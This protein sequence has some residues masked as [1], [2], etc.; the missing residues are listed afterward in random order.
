MIAEWEY[1]LV[2]E[3]ARKFFNCPQ[4]IT[5]LDWDMLRDAVQEHRIK[6]VLE[7]GPGLST[8]LWAI[9]GCCVDTFETD[10]KYLFRVQ[11]W[12]ECT[13][14][15]DLVTFHLWENTD[16]HYIHGQWD[17]VFVDGAQPRDLQV[18]IA[19]Q[20]GKYICIH[21]YKD[22]KHYKMVDGYPVIGQTK[23]ALMVKNETH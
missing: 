2:I 3:F 20:Y 12:V 13:P 4:V 14:A 9:N 19:K 22:H 5:K 15:K 21:N 23:D 6:S 18:K 8:C 10:P 1:K 16:N 11:T 7:F 17:L